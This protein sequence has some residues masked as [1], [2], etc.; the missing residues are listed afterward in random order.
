MLSACVLIIAALALLAQG[1]VAAERSSAADVR[2]QIEPA[3]AAAASLAQAAGS[4]G[5]ALGSPAG[6][7]GFDGRFRLDG[8]PSEQD[9]A[10][11]ARI[12]ESSSGGGLIADG[13]ILV[14]IV[15]RADQPPPDRFA[16]AGGARGRMTP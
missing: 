12:A 4:A 3:S 10:L 5:S 8:A 9:S 13:E 16:A 11:S 15:D 6:G 14:A 1:A 7:L 2:T